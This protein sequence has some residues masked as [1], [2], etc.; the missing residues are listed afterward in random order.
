MKKQEIKT[1][2]L[3]TIP[4]FYDDVFTGKKKFE[5][6]KD[7]RDFKVGDTLLLR[8]WNPDTEQYTG[9]QT[10]FEI[11]YKLRSDFNF[12]ILP[13]YCVLSLKKQAHC[14]DFEPKGEERE[15]SQHP[16]H[17]ITAPDLQSVA[18]IGEAPTS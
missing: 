14:A 8:E 13:G 4:P 18:Q 9:R 10:M 2:I 12:G 11:G 3:K 1:H 16:T 17:G 7:D 15:N 6:R 5:V